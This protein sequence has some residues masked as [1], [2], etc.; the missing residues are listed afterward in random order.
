MR[1]FAPAFTVAFLAVACGTNPRNVLVI[2]FDGG[3]DA[4][5][6]DARAPAD[7]SGDEASPYLGGP[8]I[9]DA[10]CNDN[11]ACTYDSCDKAAGRC[12]NVPDDTQ[13]DDHVY[14]DGHEQCA[15]RLGCQPGPPVSCD[16]GDP[17]QIATCVEATKSCTY[18]ERDVD[19]DGD[20]DA[21]CVAH[22]DCDDLDPNVSSLHAEVCQNGIDDNC[23]GV[24]DEQPCVSPVGDTCSN[25]VPVAGAATV[26]LSTVGASATF[27][28]SCSVPTPL[29]AQNVVVAITVPPGPHADLELWAT[30][31]GSAVAVAIDATCGQASSELACGGS[32]S[33][34]SVRARAYDLPPGTYYAVV[35]TQS[36][37]PVELQVNLLAAS[38]PP[39]NVDCA[40]AAPIQ[41]GTPVPVAIVAP[42]TT[43][44]S[45]CTANTGE[46]TYAFTLAAPQD[47]HVYASTVRGSG[48]PVIGLRDPAC[49]GQ[50]DEIGCRSGSAVPIFERSLPAGQYVVTVAASSPIDA[51]LE[52]DVAPPTTLPADQTCAAP[53]PAPA[54]GRVAV[55]L[56]AHEDAIKDGCDPGGPDAVY[57]VALPVA[58]D[59]LLVGRFP[60]TEAAAVALDAPACDAFSLLA[61]DV[62]GAIPRVGKRNVPAGDYR[63]VVTD[64]LGLQGSLDVLVR[65]TVVPT[66]LGPGMGDTCAQALAIDGSQGGGGFFTGDTS[67]S[68]PDYTSG[69][70]A[71]G[72]P[73]AAD[74]LLSLNLTQPQRVVFDMEGSAYTT[75]LDIRQGATCP[76]A[77]VMGGC[78]V[79]FGPQRSFLDIELLA[80]TYWIVIDG[81]NQAKG[82]WDLDVRVL[83]P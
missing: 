69:C 6:P 34:T 36:A 80:G 43:L 72:V 71:P 13:C 35:T 16:N 21:H 37:G 15:P 48:V 81:Y 66:I 23:N 44:A 49:S 33:A 79:G 82:A 70:D 51:S 65:P 17:C 5:S 45:A 39:A 63:A 74:Q 42:P 30:S 41:P 11:L 40:S 28:T 77:P 29:G 56:S 57:D 47:V 12:L 24:V 58:S 52:V 14:C 19:Q 18:K 83:P 2:H 3:S 46:L 64:Q 59:V 53:P 4:S 62:E 75:I 25:A 20:P 68:M 50:T 7:A 76:G 10:Q 9:D 31:T 54:N 55:D 27:A 1:L 61:C 78:F 22:H 8:C 38:S 32:G 73:P 26:E 67:T 60:D